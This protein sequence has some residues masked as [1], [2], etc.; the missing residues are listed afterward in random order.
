MQQYTTVF[1]VTQ[2]AFSWW[3]PTLGLVFFA[4][5]ILGLLKRK[6]HQWA[7]AAS[8]FAS[9]WMLISFSSTYSGHREGR[10]IYESGNYSVV[11]GRVDNFHPIPFL[12][13]DRECFSVQRSRFCYSDFVIQPGFNNTS[14]RGGPIRSGLPVRVS[15]VGNTI[16]KL[17]IRSDAAPSPQE[18]TRRKINSIL[19][20]A[21]WLLW[22]PAIGL[23]INAG[24]WV[25]EKLCSTRTPNPA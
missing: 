17:E 1:D 25:Y 11:E 12:S 13:N 14:G 4:F 24:I 7:Y 19:L 15:Y 2:R 23:A 9:A 5:G 18:M 16:L 10:K 20:G 22:L 21:L 6:S 3:F 8:L